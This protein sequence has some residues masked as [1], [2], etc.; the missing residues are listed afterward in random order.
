MVTNAG[1]VIR[2]ASGRCCRS[3]CCLAVKGR[4]VQPWTKCKIIRLSLSRCTFI[5]KKHDS[6]EKAR[7]AKK[8]LTVWNLRACGSGGDAELG[9]EED[10]LTPASENGLSLVTQER[11]RQSLE[12]R[13]SRTWETRVLGHTTVAADTSRTAAGVTQGREDDCEVVVESLKKGR[14]HP[15]RV[16]GNGDAGVFKGGGGM[17]F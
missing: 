13:M 1:R 4:L 9:A 3:K 15:G 12:P 14:E 10:Y 8:K 2:C 11:G 6:V 7:N 16:L 5:G 17:H